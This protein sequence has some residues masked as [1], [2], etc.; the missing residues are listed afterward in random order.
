M[1]KYFL[2]KFTDNWADEIDVDGFDT[3]TEEEV[4]EF[5]NRVTSYF[6]ENSEPYIYSIGTNEELEYYDAETLL[7]YF[8]F[9]EITK[10]EYDVIK[11]LFPY[12]YGFIPLM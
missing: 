10:E 2:V 11:K 1:S 12:S 7:S 4:K 6:D 8:T 5:K 9:K 3:L